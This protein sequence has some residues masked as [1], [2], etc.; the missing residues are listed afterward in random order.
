MP[1]LSP[2]W[3]IFA[4]VSVAPR[5]PDVWISP[6]E[7]SLSPWARDSTDSGGGRA[8]AHQSAPSAVCPILPVP[9]PVAFHGRP[10]P[11]LR[12]MRP[13]RSDA[14]QWSEGAAVPGP[15]KADRAL[16]PAAVCRGRRGRCR[17]VRAGRHVQRRRHRDDRD[18]RRLRDVQCTPV[19]RCLICPA[20]LTERQTARLSRAG[21]AGD[22]HG[23]LEGVG[24]VITSEACHLKA[25]ISVIPEM[26]LF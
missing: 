25:D 1:R 11:Q 13:S 6:M 22:R 21:T 7:G 26:Q 16:R 12:P 9:I 5:P 8:L 23:S 15:G 17:G 10:P 3:L 20:R 4:S 14:R 19:A 2:L 24:G 18:S